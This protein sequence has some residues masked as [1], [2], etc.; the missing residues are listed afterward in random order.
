MGPGLEEDKLGHPQNSGDIQ[1]GVGLAGGMPGGPE[2]AWGTRVEA[3]VGTLAEIGVDISV[4]ELPENGADCPDRV[5]LGTW[6][7]KAVVVV[8]RLKTVFLAQ[9]HMALVLVV[10]MV[11]V[12]EGSLK[13]KKTGKARKPIINNKNAKCWSSTYVMTSIIF[14]Y[15]ILQNPQTNTLFLFYYWNDISTAHDINLQAISLMT[16]TYKKNV[17]RLR[18]YG[19]LR[20]VFSQI[21]KS[22]NTTPTP[23]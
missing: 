9:E 2:V 23:E 1:V 16:L 8:G 14:S 15:S 11:A 22:P 20:A 6:A 12:E 5:G 18:L 19:E 21:S 3:E 17:H 7:Q 4:G 13:K 10:H